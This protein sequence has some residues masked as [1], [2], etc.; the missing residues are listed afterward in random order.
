MSAST[1][2]RYWAQAGKCFYGEQCNFA[3]VGPDEAT[4]AASGQGPV[5]QGPPPVGP[6]QGRPQAEA[7]AGQAFQPK[8]QRFCRNLALHGFC[9]YEGMGC[10]FVHDRSQAPA[11]Q[12]QQQQQQQQ[13][14]PQQG[15]EQEQRR[16][17]EQRPVGNY[18][19][20]PMMAGMGGGA[21]PPYGGPGGGGPPPGTASV[22]QMYG[23]E[24]EDYSGPFVPPQPAHMGYQAGYGQ[25][26]Q[27][28]FQ[29]GAE[30]YPP[31]VQEAG[32]DQYGYQA[33][34]AF[35]QEQVAVQQGGTTFFYEQDDV[36][37]A[38][39]N[40]NPY[41]TVLHQASMP[42]PGMR[43]MDSFLMPLDISEDL[44]AKTAATLE[45]LPVD[46]PRR[47]DLPATVNNYHSL[48]P[49][50]DPNKSNRSTVF[51]FS[52]ALY[53][54]MC[55][56]DG[57]PYTLRRVDGFRLTSE[58][59]LSMVAAWTSVQHSNIVT[60]R[61]VFFSDEFGTNAL[62]FVHDFYPC[63]RTLELEFFSQASNAGLLPEDMLWSFISQVV[64]AL[65]SLHSAGLAS[66]VVDASKILVTG[67]NRYRLGCTGVFDVLR[68]DDGQNVQ[69]FQQEDLMSL[70]K[71]VLALACR[72][73]SAVE[74]I[75]KSLQVVTESYSQ[76]LHDF[77]VQLVTKSDSYPA[78]DQ[79]AVSVA[80]F[81]LR[82]VE[83][84]HQYTDGLERAL[85]MEAEN[86]RL[87]RLMA[88][89]GF[90][91]ERPEHALDP[92]WSETGDRYLLKLFR[93]Y[94]FHQVYDGGIPV[95]D[96]G[97]VLDTL[98]KLDAGVSEKLML[99]SR[100]EKSVLIVSYADLKRSVEAAFGELLLA[101]QTVPVG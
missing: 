92:N 8:A 18:Q 89:L 87:F 67:K 35:L 98:N 101:G 88:K 43:N 54:A 64:S 84:L 71:I 56:L 5:A 93:D 97:H 29:G 22:P 9:K 60:L 53:K 16:R 21:M 82:E 47:A 1:V 37:R 80:P 48:F 11:G 50:D 52:T 20:Q 45:Q 91:N 26:F 28:Q 40:F 100:N 78:A 27:P 57:L 83:Y 86:G 17:M 65:A 96:F 62:Y 72:S 3:H 59:S 31:P 23:R 14:P 73:S 15:M 79:I 58:Q 42:Q 61:D 33:H 68:F 76:D 99:I 75:H 70:G 63:A 49:L 46:D 66:R 30:Y 6:P 2:C 81:L 10:E 24:R 90:I 34:E 44:K 38:P 51:G 12:F 13:A 95:V 4:R 94:V 55:T 77:I 36:A 7:G 25:E 39:Q 69:H 19:S 32:P 85:A 41:T 74:N